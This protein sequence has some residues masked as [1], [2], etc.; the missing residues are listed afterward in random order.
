MRVKKKGCA[1]ALLLVLGT[2][3]YFSWRLGA[4]HRLAMEAHQKIRAGMTPREVYA[5][6]GPWFIASGSE[7]GGASE[8]LAFYSAA[9]YGVEGSGHLQL[10]RRKP[11]AAPETFHT[12]DADY[13][14]RAA[15]L[16][17]VE[18]TPALSSCMQ[19]CF[20]YRVSG[21]PPKASFTVR[22]A[23]G[24]STRVSEPHTWD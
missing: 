9:G 1:T 22:F 5:V 3:G 12:Q 16:E 4:P 14:S 24:K 7:C 11:G 21:V 20:T 10:S 13:A 18:R 17:I 8:P 23:D 6:S 19:I 15:L 2:C